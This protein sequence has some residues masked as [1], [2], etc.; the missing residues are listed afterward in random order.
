MIN[1]PLAEGEE[2]AKSG[3]SRVFIDFNQLRLGENE[4]IYITKSGLSQLT[5]LNLRIHFDDPNGNLELCSYNL[6]LT[7]TK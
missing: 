3:L 4:L 2:L 7:T 1:P 5:Y 6:Q